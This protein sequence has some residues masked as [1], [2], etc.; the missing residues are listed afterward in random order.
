MLTRRAL[1]VSRY[2]TGTL[3]RSR[4]TDVPQPTTS[5]VPTRREPPPNE[6]LEVVRARLLYQSKKRGI[7]ENDIIIGGFAE[8]TL[9]TLSRSE[10][11][12]YDRLINGEH[13]EWDLFHYVS[14]KIHSSAM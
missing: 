4:A 11:A 14:G 9:P 10:L 8:E 13:M 7:L 6:P 12:D 3:R 2:V 5:D 1:V